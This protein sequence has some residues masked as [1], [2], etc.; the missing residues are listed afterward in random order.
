[1]LTAVALRGFLLRLI[2]RVLLI[3]YAGLMFKPA[4]P[5]V[6]DAMAHTF[7]HSA[8]MKIVH[9]VNGKEHVHYELCK[10]TKDGEKQKSTGKW[11]YEPG[12]EMIV[13]RAV[14]VPLAT[15]VYCSQI[16]A[17][18]LQVFPES[19]DDPDFLPPKA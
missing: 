15:T 3:A 1:M 2:S 6:M 19:F 18:V 7:W 12:D 16:Y 10:V 13:N 14:E 5:V 4:M 8:H 17:D 11:K 9:R